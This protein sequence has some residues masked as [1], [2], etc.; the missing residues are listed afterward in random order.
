MAGDERRSIAA[1]DARM[2]TGDFIVAFNVGW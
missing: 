2:V 1:V